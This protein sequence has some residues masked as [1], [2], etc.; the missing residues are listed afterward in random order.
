ML[1]NKFFNDAFLLHEENDDKL[2]KEMMSNV[3]KNGLKWTNKM[4]EELKK[5]MKLIR[6]MKNKRKIAKYDWKWK[7]ELFSLRLL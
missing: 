6:M 3:I 2:F 1:E 5:L 7:R 4:I